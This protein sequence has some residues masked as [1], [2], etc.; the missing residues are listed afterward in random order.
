MDTRDKSEN[1]S[2][3]NKQKMKGEVGWGGGLK[4]NGKHRTVYCLIM[5]W[6]QM[7]VCTAHYI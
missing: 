3:K 4:H 1:Y 7:N 5:S 6:Y 2:T